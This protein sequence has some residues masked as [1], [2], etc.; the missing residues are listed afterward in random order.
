MSFKYFDVQPIAGRIGA[1]IVGID[2]SAEL[3]NEVIASLRKAL[4]QYK[5]I[6]FRRQQ[7][8][9][10]GQVAFA[11]QFGEVTTAHPTVPSLPDHRRFLIWIMVELS[12]APIL[13]IPMSPL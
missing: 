5:V 2:L 7:L 9:A 11:R 13:G 3:G 4:I 12:I 6:F 8:D 10:K 1:E